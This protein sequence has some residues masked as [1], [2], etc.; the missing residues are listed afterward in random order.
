MDNLNEKMYMHIYSGNVRTKKDWLYYDI[1][2]NVVRCLVSEERAVEVELDE[3]GNW[4]E[5]S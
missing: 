2:R 5:V 1:N 4:I 3:K